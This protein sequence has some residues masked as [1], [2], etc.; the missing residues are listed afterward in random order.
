M[1]ILHV[2]FPVPMSYVGWADLMIY[3]CCME[4]QHVL[5]VLYLSNKDIQINN[6]V[7]LTIFNKHITIIIM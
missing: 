7:E 4:N 2:F 1:K 3:K 6:E 5:K